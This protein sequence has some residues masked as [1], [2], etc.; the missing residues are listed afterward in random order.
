MHTWRDFFFIT[1]PKTQDTLELLTCTLGHKTEFVSNIL[2]HHFPKH[3]PRHMWISMPYFVPLSPH[4][5]NRPLQS[6]SK[7][8]VFHL[9]MTLVCDNQLDLI[10]LCCVGNLKYSFRE[11]FSYM[12]WIDALKEKVITRLRTVIAENAA[13][14]NA[15]IQSCHCVHGG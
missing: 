11:K 9:P 15:L 2:L 14:I 13:C 12:R 4:C 5:I 6:I 1:K 8:K 10:P 3:L 7:T